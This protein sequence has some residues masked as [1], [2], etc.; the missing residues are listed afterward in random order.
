M[1]R[2]HRFFIVLLAAFALLF[3][4]RNAHAQTPQNASS[5]T[6]YTWSCLTAPSQN[7]NSVVCDENNKT[8]TCTHHVQL[9]GK[10]TSK[11]ESD[12]YVVACV[13]SSL[14]TRCTTG[15]DSSDETVGFGKK[16]YTAIV[17]RMPHFYFMVQGGNKI[18]AKAGQH[19]IRPTIT[20]MSQDSLQWSFY[21]IT[22]RKPSASPDTTT[23]TA[24]YRGEL[25]PLDNK[26]LEFEPIENPSQGYCTSFSAKPQGIV[27]DSQSL[28]PL[29]GVA[30]TLL[31]TRKIK[32]FAAGMENPHKTRL[33]GTYFFA[34]PPGT[35]FLQPAGLVS[36][37]F[38]EKPYVHPNYTKAYAN[39]YK[40]AMQIVETKDVKARNDIAL[41]PGV[42]T[43][44]RAPVASMH[45]A[46]EQL[47]ENSKITG[48]TTHPFT[49][50]SFRQRNTE[51]KATTADKYGFYEVRIPN[52]S[53]HANEPIDAYISKLNLTKNKAEEPVKAFSLDPIPAYIEGIA[54]T[55]DGTAIANATIVVKIDHSTIVYA[56]THADEAG[57]FVLDP[58]SLPPV[59]YS[60]EFS[61]PKSSNTTNLTPREFAAINKDY[62][63]KN[64]INLMTASIQGVSLIKKPTDTITQNTP[65]TPGLG[66]IASDSG[67]KKALPA[68][69]LALALSLAFVLI[70]M[71]AGFVIVTL[72]KTPSKSQDSD[73]A[74]TP[75]TSLM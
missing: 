56:S 53:V 69:N 58:K 7:N 23:D 20:Y 57:K 55:T 45:Y 28:E 36:H 13:S 48:K 1:V 17:S 19:E 49:I 41:D 75:P 31:D 9:T 63:T 47:G 72:R 6:N 40:P 52:A 33:D 60:L 3:V 29:P 71:V 24:K 16:N 38:V 11:T 39:I 22:T 42:N 8:N 12:C 30:I 62:L 74:I 5:T 65:L 43:P 35:Y 10:C 59:A 34:P 73:D 4:S 50:V 27:F 51:I 14:G 64:N 54:T 46:L 2:V 25:K 68:T 15:S 44:Y 26:L 37:A 61:P 66:G 70:F 21:A 32:A 67:T 18:S